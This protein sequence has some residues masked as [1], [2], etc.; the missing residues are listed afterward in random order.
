MSI[1][2]D[3]G[4]SI[5]KGAGY[6]IGRNIAGGLGKNRYTSQSSQSR[7]LVSDHYTNR[8]INSKLNRSVFDVLEESKESIQYT[9]QNK[10]EVSNWKSLSSWQ[11]IGFFGWGFVIFC[12]IPFLNAKV[13][14]PPTTPISTISLLVISFVI[15]KLSLRLLHLVTKTKEQREEEAKKFL[16]GSLGAVAKMEDAY[17]K[18]LNMIKEEQ[19]EEWVELYETRTPTVGMHIEP[20]TMFFG[21]PQKEEVTDKG[22][23]LIYGTSKQAGDWFRFEGQYLKSFTIK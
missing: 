15:A 4:K 13:F 19:G 1:A 18:A 11:K 9:Y 21:D 5:I 6:T 14:V 10:L 22:K 8:S 16:E 12:A 7:S 20:F 23:N 2:A 3:F 17:R